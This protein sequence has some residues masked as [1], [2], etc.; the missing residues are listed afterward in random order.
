MPKG[1]RKAEDGMAEKLAIYIDDKEE[2]FDEILEMKDKQKKILIQLKEIRQPYR[3]ILYKRYIK[4]KSFVR[5]ADEM[6]YDFKYTTNMNSK[7][8][9]EFDKIGKHV[10]KNG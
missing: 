6:N 4:G 2:L 3:N 7:A 9:N 5:I 1:S 8:L 10:E